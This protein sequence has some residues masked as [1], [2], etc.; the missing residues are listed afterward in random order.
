MIFRAADFRLLTAELFALWR[1]SRRGL[2]FLPE[3]RVGN[4]ER[5]RGRKA[6][7]EDGAKRPVVEDIRIW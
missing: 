6:R 1:T 4:A 5:R 7:T 3:A 2:S